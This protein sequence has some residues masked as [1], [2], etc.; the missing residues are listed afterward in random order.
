MARKVVE[1]Q[2]SS[3]TDWIVVIQRDGKGK[4]GSTYETQQFEKTTTLADNHN[5]IGILDSCLSMKGQN[6]IEGTSNPRRN[7]KLKG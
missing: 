4:S 6:D 5:M 1:G 3:N 2:C 7:K